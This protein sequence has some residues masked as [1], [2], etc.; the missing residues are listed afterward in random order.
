MRTAPCRCSRR[1]RPLAGAIVSERDSDRWH[2]G[3][4]RGRPQASLARNAEE[5][6]LCRTVPEAPSAEGAARRLAQ[7]GAS[8]DKAM[9]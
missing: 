2:W 8:T 9:G 5:T 4:S 3:R 1:A 7:H 6:P